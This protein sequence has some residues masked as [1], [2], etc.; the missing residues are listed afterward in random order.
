MR[1]DPARSEWPTTLAS[2]EPGH[3]ATLG[4]AAVYVLV[5]C[6]DTPVWRHVCRW[7]Y[8]AGALVTFSVEH[9]EKSG[10][11]I[12]RGGI[13]GTFQSQVKVC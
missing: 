5:G 2:P 3:T 10:K 1:V 12:A 11:V 9:E 7:Q 4:N 8:V 6:G 13:T